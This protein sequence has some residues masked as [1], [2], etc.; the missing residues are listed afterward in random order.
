MKKTYLILFAFIG[1]VAIRQAS[2]QSLEPN[3]LDWATLITEFNLVQDKPTIVSILSTNCPPCVAHRNDIMNNVLNQC[4]NPDLRWLI[5]WF[6][7]PFPGHA[8]TRAQTEVRAAELQ[9]NLGNCRVKQWW[10]QEHQP[11]QPKNDSVAYLYGNSWLTCNYPWDMTILYDSGVSW[12]G[13]DPPNGDYCIIRGSCP[14]CNFYNISGF[15][16]QVDLLNV[17]D[18]QGPIPPHVPPVAQWS[19]TSAGKL[20]TFTDESDSTNGWYWDFGDGNTSTLQNPQHAYSDTGIYNVCQRV[21]REFCSDSSC[22]TIN[23]TTV[24]VE[25]I[26]QGQNIR[27]F[28]NPTPGTIN[29]Q[30]N[31]AGGKLQITDIYGRIVQEIVLENA[32]GTL[33]LNLSTGIYLYSIWEN[34]ELMGRNKLVIH[35]Y[36]R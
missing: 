25:N 32:K 10:Y 31:K 3:D 23:V 4:D 16:T 18:K 26:S 36:S 27:I 15:K 7:D 13:M 34:G 33:S 35:P 1:V 28:P 21:T 19:H 12:T 20:V 24:G 14:S 8:S 29:Y 11:F 9:D 17:C 6:E 30:L 2:A 5:I 22:K